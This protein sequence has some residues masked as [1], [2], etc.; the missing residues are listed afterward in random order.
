[1]S[2]KALVVMCDGRE[3]VL[4]AEPHDKFWA[5]RLMHVPGPVNDMAEVYVSADLHRMLRSQ[6]H[7]PGLAHYAVKFKFIA[8][9]PTDRAARLFQTVGTPKTPVTPAPQKQPDPQQHSDSYDYCG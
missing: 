1:M 6:D 5:D 3:F 2:D 7:I 4:A 8:D 9:L